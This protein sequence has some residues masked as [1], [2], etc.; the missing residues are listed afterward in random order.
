MGILLKKLSKTRWDL[1]A[2]NC[3]MH[4]KK[5]NL[6]TWTLYLNTWHIWTLLQRVGWKP[7]FMGSSSR[8]VSYIGA[9][10]FWIYLSKEYDVI[11]WLVGDMPGDH[12]VLVVTLLISRSISIVSPRQGQ[13]KL[14][15]Y[16]QIWIQIVV[17]SLFWFE[18]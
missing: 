7:T 14:N 3:T 1:E 17:F 8:S 9:R 12:K 2:S 4:I 13:T 15:E 18:Y 16:G 11:H 6:I 5:R 10:I